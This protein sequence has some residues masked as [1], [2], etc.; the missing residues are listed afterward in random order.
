MIEPENATWK[1]AKATNLTR[2]AS[3]TAD[4][5]GEPA[6]ALEEFEAAMEV[7]SQ[8]YGETPAVPNS[9][10]NLQ[11]TVSSIVAAMGRLNEANAADRQMQSSH[12]DHLL[13]VYYQI[14]GCALVLGGS[15]D[16]GRSAVT[17]I[18]DAAD[19]ARRIERSVD[20]IEPLRVA[21]ELAR[22]METDNYYSTMSETF[23]QACKLRQRHA[24]A[25]L[26]AGRPREALEIIEETTSDCK[27]FL[28]TRQYDLYL[29]S[30]V[31]GAMQTKALALQ[32][33]GEQEAARA[34]LR[35]CVQ[36]GGTLCQTPYIAML[37][38]GVG[39]PVD[40]EETNRVRELKGFSNMKRFTVPVAAKGA[41]LT[42]PFHVYIFERP[43]GWPY[44]GI[45]DQA[46][47]LEE[48]RGLIIP[49]DVR[50]SFI[51]LEK[52]ALENKVPFPDLAVY[53]LGMAQEDAP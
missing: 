21:A 16:C 27:Q 18:L 40:I 11:W 28:L 35:N 5:R 33:L 45:E 49:A 23:Y 34:V 52:I 48:N 41:L 47:W 22:Q 50:D 17:A 30:T 32:A 7:W 53:A 26:K 14:E 31:S 10:A 51:K 46:L 9:F 37:E 44:A 3:A 15:S 24:D 38:N 6:S 42:Y 1:A 8:I 29:R 36:D 20:L 19:M 4:L 25:L 39:G 2:R 13:R 12:V 43:P